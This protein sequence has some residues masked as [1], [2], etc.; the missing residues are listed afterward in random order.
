MKNHLDAIGYIRE[1]ESEVNLMWFSEICKRVILDDD[2]SNQHNL[3]RKWTN[4]KKDYLDELVEL[5][6]KRSSMN[7]NAAIEQSSEI[8]YNKSEKFENND[9]S[10]QTLSKIKSLSNFSNFKKLG[11]KVEICFN[12]RITLIFGENGSGK[13]SVYTAL[14]VLSD[15][16]KPEETLSFVAPN[17]YQTPGILSSNRKPKKKANESSSFEYKTDVTAGTWTEKQGYGQ[18]EREMRCYSFDSLADETKEHTHLRVINSK[19]LKMDKFDR[20]NTFIKAFRLHLSDEIDRDASKLREELEDYRFKFGSRS[21]GEELIRM[22]EELIQMFDENLLTKNQT[23]IDRFNKILKCLEASYE[24]EYQASEDELQEINNK[25][26]DISVV[27][28]EIEHIETYMSRLV[29]VQEKASNLKNLNQ[30]VE[31]LNN[32]S[33]QKKKIASKVLKHDLGVQEEEV[34]KLV[35]NSRNVLQTVHEKKSKCPL[36][37]RKLSAKP[38]NIFRQYLDLIKSIENYIIQ[39]ESNDVV[40]KEISILLDIGGKVDLPLPPETTR[41]LNGVLEQLKRSCKLFIEKKTKRWAKELENDIQKLVKGITDVESIVV[42]KKQKVKDLKEVENN[43]YKQK[44]EAENRLYFYKQFKSHRNELKELYGRITDFSE[45]SNIFE[46]LSKR[47]QQDLDKDLSFKS[48]IDKIEEKRNDTSKI[49]EIDLIRKRVNKEFKTLTNRSLSSYGLDFEKNKNGVSPAVSGEKMR[50]IFSEGEIKLYSIS[51]FFAEVEFS[52]PNII[53]FDDP[54]TSLDHKFEERYVDRILDFLEKTK[55]RQIILFTHNLGFFNR[56]VYHLKRNKKQLNAAQGP[57]L[58]KQSLKRINRENK[59]INKRKKQLQEELESR[60]VAKNLEK[61]PKGQGKIMGLSDEQKD[62]AQLLQSMDKLTEKQEKYYKKSK[63]EEKRLKETKEETR[64]KTDFD[65]F[66]ILDC[67]IIKKVDEKLEDTQEHIEEG[68]RK[69]EDKHMEDTTTSF[70]K[71]G[72]IARMREFIEIM[73]EELVFKG[74]RYIYTPRMLPN[75]SFHRFRDLRPLTRCEA[76]T[77]SK[78]YHLLCNGVH[79]DRYSYKPPQEKINNLYS[80]IRDKGHFETLKELV[81]TL[82]EAPDP[83]SI[84]GC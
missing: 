43:H 40:L 38:L 9:K 6:W 84:E 64:M 45:R 79:D 63:E 35:Y 75:S 34:F 49:L 73:I 31:L 24:R 20:I 4:Q 81:E 46:K 28:A 66:K 13:S 15:N 23:Q 78:I 76:N 14:R 29:S 77:L 80:E 47:K 21:N 26:C 33:K 16:K 53:V 25:L 19:P 11:R 48:I 12:E 62:R 10:D 50:H 82:H 56:L 72:I 61:I 36:C 59:R 18:F 67:S 39:I 74:Q 30:T 60:T 68:L 3:K 37:L 54:I 58:I 69:L 2:I 57:Y 51:L 42:C 7:G 1:L 17:T 44:E 52:N 8:F 71:Q 55:D 41:S 65:Y 32:L 70:I 22:L 83:K 5:F 27:K